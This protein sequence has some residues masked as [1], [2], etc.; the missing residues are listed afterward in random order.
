[1]T[2]KEAHRALVTYSAVVVTKPQASACS[3]GS[4]AYYV[5]TCSWQPPKEQTLEARICGDAIPV[6][7]L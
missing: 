4:Q 5:R 1:M 7:E 3:L 2:I 6:V